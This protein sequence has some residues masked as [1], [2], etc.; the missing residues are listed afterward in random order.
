[1]I[2]IS[3]I[4]EWSNEDLENQFLERRKSSDQFGLFKISTLE[5]MIT[6]LKE[7]NERGLAGKFIGKVKWETYCIDFE[8]RQV[9]GRKNENISR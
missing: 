2:E 9:R 3:K 1:M 5:E 6:I 7:A 8:E 4:K